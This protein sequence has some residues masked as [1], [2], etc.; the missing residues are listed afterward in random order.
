MQGLSQIAPENIIACLA[1]KGG[2][3]AQARHAGRHIR[4]RP[5]GV[6]LEEGVVLL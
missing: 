4:R 2:G 6:P 1:D 5:A 3:T